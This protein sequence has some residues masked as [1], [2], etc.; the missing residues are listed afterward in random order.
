M[1]V[2]HTHGYKYISTAW[3]YPLMRS[4]N[5]THTGEI[6]TAISRQNLKRITYI[7][8]QAE[9]LGESVWHSPDATVVPPSPGVIQVLAEDI[10]ILG[11]MQERY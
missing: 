8:H 7:Y 9:A 1:Y 10:T 6:S 3:C 11:L 2:L 4:I 5:T